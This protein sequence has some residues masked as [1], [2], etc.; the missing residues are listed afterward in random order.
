[1]HPLEIIDKN[2][3][4]VK[5]AIEGALRDNHRLKGATKLVAVSKTKP[6]DVI[7]QAL[8]AGQR[9]FGENRV[10]EAEE[11]WLDLKQLYPD[12]Q[13]HLIGPL[14]T[15]KAAL[16]VS[17]FDVIETIDRLKLATAISR[18][19]RD[20]GR[21]IRCFI[22]VNTGEE[23]QKGGI[24]PAEADGFIQTCITNLSL[25]VEGL[26]CIPPAG[27][28]PALHFSLLR[29]IAERNNIRELSMG[30]SADY[31]TAIQFGATYVR[32]GTAIFGS[33]TK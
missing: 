23:R 31:A 8:K 18:H 27:E 33:R 10:K 28:E 21:K 2:L 11:K 24:F 19:M 9:V 3:T 15:N 1:M 30:M 5:Q 16:A 20:T 14:Q 17:L 22:Q 13:L 4:T 29:K 26:M 25:P 12:T 7:E 6:R 32:I